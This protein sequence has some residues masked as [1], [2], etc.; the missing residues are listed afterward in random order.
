MIVKNEEDMLEACL[1]SVAELSDELV[2]TDTGSTDNTTKIAES[3]GAKLS[4]FEWT[5]DF[6]AA[7]NFSLSQATGMWILLIDADETLE[8]GGAAKVRDLLKTADKDAYYFYVRDPSRDDMFPQIRL[9]RNDGTFR[10]E[11]AVHNQLMRAPQLTTEAL[12]QAEIFIDHYG[13]TEDVRARKNKFERNINLLSARLEAEP[14]S[15]L[16]L[17]CLANEYYAN[18]DLAS[19]LA[20]F[21]R[22]E[23]TGRTLDADAVR[24]YADTLGKSGLFEEA[25]ALLRTYIPNYPDHPDLHLLAGMSLLSLGRLDQARA[26]FNTCLQLKSTGLPYRTWRG[27]TTNL[28]YNGLALVLLREKRYREG[29]EQLEQSLSAAPQDTYAARRLSVILK[30]LDGPAKAAQKIKAL[31]DTSVADIKEILRELEDTIG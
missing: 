29:A 4:R 8:D 21:R 26:A 25:L 3:F 10:Y 30:A 9:F 13:Y 24:D 12:G 16:Y 2:I 27:S 14:E 23:A 19:A 31:A 11:S 28:A 20:V 7:R 6:A 15:P 5:N 17:Y 22:L 18:K 1:R